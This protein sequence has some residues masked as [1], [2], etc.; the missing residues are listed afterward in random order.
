MN[1]EK[2]WFPFICP[3]WVQPK[4]HLG[5]NLNSMF[6][7]LSP[8]L[9]HK[10]IPCP[11]QMYWT[12]DRLKNYFSQGHW[13]FLKVQIVGI[14]GEFQHSKSSDANKLQI[15]VTAQ[16]DQVLYRSQCITLTRT[17]KDIN[18]NFTIA[19]RDIPTRVTLNLLLPRNMN[20]QLI[21]L[22]HRRQAKTA[23]PR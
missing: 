8:H 13:V 23:R 17:D 16:C 20:Y 11:W 12:V 19:W 21:I 14:W 10:D 7:I 22:T 18:C 1:I 6:W 9:I 15:I 4:K 2:G 3:S 5:S